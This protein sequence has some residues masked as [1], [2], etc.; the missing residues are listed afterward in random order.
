M[1]VA[2]NHLITNTFTFFNCNLQLIGFVDNNGIPATFINVSRTDN[3]CPFRLRNCNISF[4]NIM[5]THNRDCITTN[6]FTNVSIIRFLNCIIA[7]Y[8]SGCIVAL[9]YGG[10]VYFESFGKF[11]MFFIVNHFF[12]CLC[13]FNVRQLPYSRL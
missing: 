13:L 10:F 11:K 9:A 4:T 2:K 1:F 3:N 12:L 7:R 5:I 8:G 6:D